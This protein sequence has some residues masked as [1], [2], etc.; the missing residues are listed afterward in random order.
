MLQPSYIVCYTV[1]VCIH[2]FWEVYENNRETYEQGRRGVGEKAKS[3][4]CLCCITSV[5]VMVRL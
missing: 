2:V 1:Y 4:I 3:N 5:V